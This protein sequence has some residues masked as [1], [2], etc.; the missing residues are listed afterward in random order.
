M[1]L[2]IYLDEKVIDPSGQRL[3][4][5]QILITANYPLLVRNALARK[6]N[7]D[8]NDRASLRDINRMFSN[9]VRV[10]LREIVTKNPQ[11][12]GT[13]QKIKVLA[14]ADIDSAYKGQIDLHVAEKTARF[15]IAK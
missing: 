14:A 2:S 13:T 8:Q 12:I 3:A 1:T 4:N 11:L 7:I 15:L 5:P 9:S 6:L 10:Q